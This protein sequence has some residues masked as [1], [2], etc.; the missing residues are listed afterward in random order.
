MAP[1]FYW[2]ILACLLGF[3][4]MTKNQCNVNY[5]LAKWYLMD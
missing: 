4:E 3:T 5:K 1:T 2:E